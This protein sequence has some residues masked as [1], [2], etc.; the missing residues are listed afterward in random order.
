M[1]ARTLR[2]VYC[3][4]TDPNYIPAPRLAENMITAGP[5][6]E[7]KRDGERLVSIKSPKGRYD[8]AALLA[9]H[10][11]TDPPDAIIVSLDATAHNEPTGLSAFDCPKVALLADTHHL[12]Q[13]L[14]NALTYLGSEKFDF[15]IA[16]YNRHH[17]HFFTAHGLRNVHWLPGLTV[18]HFDAAIPPETKREILFVGQAGKYHPRRRRLLSAIKAHG[19]PLRAVACPA[20]EAAAQYAGARITFNCSLN[21]DLN[22]R[23]FEALGAGG[24][25]LTDHLSPQSGLARL[26]KDG[27]HLALYDSPDD[28]IAKA[29]Y[30]LDHPEEAARIAR[31]GHAHY[32]E[33]FSA[34]RLT[35]LLWDLVFKGR[36]DPL[37]DIADDPR[38]ALPVTMT[39]QQIMARAALYEFV[40]EL[41]RKEERVAVLLLPGVDPG[42]AADIADLP[43]VDV[44]YPD[45]D[46]PDEAARAWFERAGVTAQ[47]RHIA[48]AEAR[49]A[50]WSVLVAPADLPEKIKPAKIKDMY[51]F[52]HLVR[53]KTP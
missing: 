52:D 37:F 40:Q 26:F 32:A 18:R 35:A 28:L 53:V 1:S 30:Y 42:M 17:A 2:L 22:M 12:A 9:E 16:L 25:L 38:A 31:Q 19:L 3:H 10:G 39:H 14:R 8:L 23:V 45:A 15:H 4:H 20:E 51:T 11:A 34:A 36:S 49:D 44:C 33:C 6:M 24:F 29:E 13:P 27:E 5:F 43:R 7:T 47:I 41:H 46:A 21:G 50:S 48:E